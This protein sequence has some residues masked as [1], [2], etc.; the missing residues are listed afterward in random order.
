[1]NWRATSNWDVQFGD[2]T[3]KQ[4]DLGISATHGNVVFF[5]RQTATKIKDVAYLTSGC[6][7]QNEDFSQP[8]LKN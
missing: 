3:F 2:S 7:Q 6:N 1:M 5:L 8:G 4:K